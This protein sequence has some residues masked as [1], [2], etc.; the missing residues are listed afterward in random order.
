MADLASKRPLGYDADS[1][2][3]SSAEIAVAFGI[4]AR[5]GGIGLEPVA[6]PDEAEIAAQSSVR[7]APMRPS[8]RRRGRSPDGRG[9]DRCCQHIGDDLIRWRSSSRRRSQEGLRDVP[10]AAATR[11]VG[12][13]IA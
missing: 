12:D 5:L 8:R 6:Q 11:V 2:R 3:Y 1:R 4:D 13:G 9:L 7:P 10:Y